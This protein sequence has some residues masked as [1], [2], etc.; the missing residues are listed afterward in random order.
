MLG[1]SLF[2]IVGS[3]KGVGFPSLHLLLVKIMM[4]SI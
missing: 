2:Q 3:S 4:Q 1:N